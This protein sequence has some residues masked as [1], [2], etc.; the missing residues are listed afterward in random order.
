M[1]RAIEGRCLCG[2]VTL[3]VGRHEPTVGACHCTM[4]RRWAGS[5]L[6]VFK[7]EDVQVEGPVKVYRSSSFAERAFCGTCGSLLWFKDRNDDDYDVQVGLFEAAREFPLTSEIYID[8][9]LACLPLEGGHRQETQAEYEAKY[10]SVDEGD[11]T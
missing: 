6:F 8:Q 3:T 5:A 7:G 1:S 4:C 11:L 10:P 9:R 2:A